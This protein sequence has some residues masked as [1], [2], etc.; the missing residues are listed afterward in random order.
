MTVPQRYAHPCDILHLNLQI[1]KNV[2]V[3]RKNNKGD[4]TPPYFTTFPF[5]HSY[6]FIE[7]API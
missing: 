3:Y 1:F 2:V 4:N 7:R 6:K 5:Q